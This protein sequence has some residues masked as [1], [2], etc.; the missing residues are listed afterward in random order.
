MSTWSSDQLIQDFNVIARFYQ[1][2][3][4]NKLYLCRNHALII[5]RGVTNIDKSDAVIVM[6]NPGSCSPS[7]PEYDAPVVHHNLINVPFVTVKADPTQFQLMRLMKIMNWNVVSIINLSDICTGKMKDFC[8]K[9]K[10]VENQN[11]KSH[12]IFSKN[13]DNERELFLKRSNKIILAW[14]KNKYIRTLAIDALKKVNTGEQ[15]IFGLQYPDSGWG[16]RHPY[17]MLKEKCNQWLME[18]SEQL[19]FIDKRVLDKK[20]K[21]DE[22]ELSQIKFKDFLLNKHRYIA[23]EKEIKEISA[24]Q[25]VNRLSNMISKNIYNGENQI[26]SQLIVKIQNQYKDW[27]T[28]VKTIYY[29]IKF[30]NHYQ[31]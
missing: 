2:R 6:A 31:I 19:G 10:E 26:D 29:Y 7:D 3:L 13:R 22:F 25:Y 24:N 16:Y 23:G 5:R 20:I 4:N 12:S 17:P 14:G 27:R 8:A 18:M 1:I 9:L 30:K 15:K 21:E 11:Y 28:Y